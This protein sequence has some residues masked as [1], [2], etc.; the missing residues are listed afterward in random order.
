MDIPDRL[1]TDPAEEVTSEDHESRAGVCGLCGGARASGIIAEA[2]K[3]CGCKKSSCAVFGRREVTGKKRHT[4]TR[5]E[6]AARDERV[7]NVWRERSESGAKKGRKWRAAEL[8]R[9]AILNR[10]DRNGSDGKWNN[11]RYPVITDC[12]ADCDLTERLVDGGTE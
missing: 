10:E 2:R 8:R 5:E 6:S 7:H 9:V 4:Y 11:S 1:H 12:S 3:S